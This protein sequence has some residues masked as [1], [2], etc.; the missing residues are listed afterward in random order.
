MFNMECCTL[1]LHDRGSLKSFRGDSGREEAWWLCIF[2]T[3]TARTE[4]LNFRG[5][6]R[7]GMGGGGGR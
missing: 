6:D 7:G 1:T 5:G 2:L 3:Q 4:G